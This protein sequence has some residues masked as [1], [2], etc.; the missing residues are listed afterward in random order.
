MAGNE[1][2]TVVNQIITQLK[3]INGGSNYNNTID[4]D[5]IQSGIVSSDKIIKYPSI[6]IASAV[7]GASRQVELGA[8]TYDVPITVEIF[9]Y[10]KDQD[11]AFD[12]ALKLASDIETA[13][14]TDE[15]LDGNVWSLG[16]RQGAGSMDEFGWCIVTLTATMHVVR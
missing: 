16:L 4:D 13:I 10:V 3:L 11:A 9:G 8:T 12:E 6:Y 2:R 15:T 7:E 1:L 5:Y 14:L